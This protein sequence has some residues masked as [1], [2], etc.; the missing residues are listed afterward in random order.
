MRK[1]DTIWEALVLLAGAVAQV[2][3]AETA[4]RFVVVQ[5]QRFDVGS[6]PDSAAQMDVTQFAVRSLTLWVVLFLLVA[7]LRTARGGADTARQYA[8]TRHELALLSAR[9]ERLER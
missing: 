3:I 4:P 9:L 2:V 8:E 6:W 1:L 7:M 5:G